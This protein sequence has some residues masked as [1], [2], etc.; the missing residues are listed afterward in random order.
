MSKKD[1]DLPDMNLPLSELVES[2][3]LL[4]R[5]IC[6][7]SKKGRY[8]KTCFSYN[9]VEERYEVNV[10][11]F[12]DYSSEYNVS[13][14]RLNT[15][16]EKEAH[17]LGMHHQQTYQTTRTYHG[18]AK[19]SAGLCFKY[20]CNIKKDDLGGTNPYH[21]NIIYPAPQSEEDGQEIASKLAYH[22]EFVRYES[23]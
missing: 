18:Y 20:S 11:V 8:S 12:T 21:A 16:S 7:S 9:T 2:N 17:G 5:I 19:V 3:E 1:Y 6:G 22:A 15:I 23:Q 10:A 13:V 14:N 4:Q